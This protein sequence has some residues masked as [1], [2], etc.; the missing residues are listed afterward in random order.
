MSTIAMDDGEV[1]VIAE[2]EEAEEAEKTKPETEIC[3]LPR[4]EIDRI[5][6]QEQARPR[7]PPDPCLL[8]ED[9]DEADQEPATEYQ[10]SMDAAGYPYW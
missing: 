4:K 2:A 3:S 1:E 9:G 5:L 10:D 7:R 6:A 8:E